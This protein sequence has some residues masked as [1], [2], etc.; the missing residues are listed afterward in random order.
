MA[1]HPTQTKVA[2]S[3]KRFRV[4]CCG[5]RWGKTI[6]ACKE[7]KGYASKPRR[8]AYIAPTYQQ[9]RDIAW[10]TLKKELA[11]AIVNVNESRL[12]LKVGCK[13]YEET[14]LI[15]LRGWEAV[16]TL[17]GQAFD[18]LV[19]DEVASMR[20]FWYGWQEVL[21][22]TL[23]DTKGEVMF[24][25]TPKGFNHFY[26]LFHKADT[27]NDFESFHFTSHENPYLPNEELDKA[28][29]ELDENQF[30]Q[31][32]LADFRKVAG[33][34]Y[35]LPDELKIAPVDPLTKTEVRLMGVDWGYRNPAAIWIG[36]LKDNEWITADE[37]KESGKTTDEIIQVIKNKISEHKI[38]KV[39]PDPAEPDRIEECRRAGI[40]VYEANK[41]I[42]GGI[43]Y[44]QNLIKQ[45]RFKICNNCT[46]TLEEINTYQYIE[47]KDGKPNKEEPDKINDHLMDAMRYAIYSYQGRPKIN[48]LASPLIKAY[49][50]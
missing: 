31:E 11:A 34:V 17:R 26:T 9:A 49:E 1:L 14:A 8:I 40:P 39:Y 7:I 18:F 23:T 36:Y 29:R 35:N 16:E 44:I 43:S 20:N 25:S 2:E 19:I 45:K 12:E 13:G 38:Y 48:M 5:R 27:D 50:Y 4:L 37:W 28:R 22:P 46:H 41:D 15:V 47:G 24:I 6:L 30:A 33:L 21:R 3:R 42:E 32:Y 10:E